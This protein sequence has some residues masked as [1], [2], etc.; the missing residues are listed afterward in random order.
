MTLPLLN[1]SG[2]DPSLWH[3]PSRFISMEGVYIVALELAMTRDAEVIVD[4]I[5]KC[6]RMS[7]Y[8]DRLDTKPTHK[9]VYLDTNIRYAG[10]S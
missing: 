5:P 1:P 6:A 4:S 3:R 8:S 10:K 2:Q 7:R 9:A